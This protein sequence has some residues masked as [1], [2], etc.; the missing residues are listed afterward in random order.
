[1]PRVKRPISK[2]SRGEASSSMESPPER[3]PMAQW[4][5]SKSDLDCYS[6][7][8]A[9]RKVISP[10]YLEPNFFEK[11][12][13]PNLQAVL[14]AQNLLNHVKI[15]EPIYPELNAVAYTTLELE[16]I[17][18]D[19]GDKIDLSDSSV[20]HPRK[21]SRQDACAMF[22]IPFDM[23][24]PTVGCLTVERRLL[25]YFI[26]Y[27]LVPRVYNLGLIM[28]EDLELMW[29]MQSNFKINWVFIIA[30]HMRRIK[31]GKVSKGLPYAIL[32]TTIFKNLNVNL[33]Q[34]KKKKLEY[35]HCIDTHILNHMK[36]ELNQPQV[37][38]QQGDEEEGV[39]AMEDVQVEPPQE[40]PSMLDLIR[41]LQ[42]IN[43]NI[44]NFQEETR[45][46]LGR[47]GRR[48]QRMETNMGIQEEEDQD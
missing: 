40:Q 8:F 34:V 18:D 23:P 28:E 20:E 35:N 36:V 33:T 39:Q 38:E 29:N 1:M 30:T 7:Y 32:W 11:H 25:H 27:N 15:K 2:R 16:F 9:P 21:Y 46:E 37:E 45:R 10:R 41:E 19:I 44:G 5:Q 48:M 47:L 24:R 12:P 14:I 6:T 3:H 4:L 26:V 17:D 22:N 13:Y 31:S 42:L 43:Q